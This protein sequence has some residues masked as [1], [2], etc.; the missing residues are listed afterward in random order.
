MCLLW[1]EAS[2]V[3]SVI[4]HSNT[5]RSV[6]RSVAK[7]SINIMFTCVQFICLF[8]CVCVSVYVWL[9][10]VEINVQQAEEDIPRV[11][12]PSI[13][14]CLVWLSA[15]AKTSI[16]KRCSSGSNCNS[17][18]GRKSNNNNNMAVSSSWSNINCCHQL[19][20]PCAHR[21][22]KNILWVS[23]YCCCCCYCFDCI[24]QLCKRSRFSFMI[25][26]FFLLLLLLLLCL[27]RRRTIVFPLTNSL[28][29]PLLFLLL[30]MLLSLLVGAHTYYTR[31]LYKRSD[32]A[33]STDEVLVIVLC[34]CCFF[35]FFISLPPSNLPRSYC[36]FNTYNNY[37]CCCFGWI[38]CFRFA[39]LL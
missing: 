32:F 25:F 24:H 15:C 5:L 7:T 3:T 12:F 28:Q 35:F 9:C 2:N 31:L 33:K 11:C 6:Q 4:S 27:M 22:A 19:D 34:C 20:A 37:D 26:F 38:A 17:G 18:N 29:L 14:I 39:L 10:A 23:G 1:L 13:F 21:C 30:L 8:T 36:L 16:T